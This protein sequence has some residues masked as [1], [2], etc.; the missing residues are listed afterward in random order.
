MKIKYCTIKDAYT[1]SS[2]LYC[3]W[4]FYGASEKYKGHNVGIRIFGIEFIFEGN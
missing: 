2:W 3:E 4:D 1:F